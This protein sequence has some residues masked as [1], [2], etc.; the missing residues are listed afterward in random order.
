MEKMNTL[1]IFKNAKFRGKY[2]IHM[3]VQIFGGESED[4]KS[5]EKIN[6]ILLCLKHI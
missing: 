6:F 4:T 5:I 3:K 2:N 1:E